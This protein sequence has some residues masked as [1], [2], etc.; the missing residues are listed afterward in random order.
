MKSP[1]SSSSAPGPR[2][3]D[4]HQQHKI[5]AVS[6]AR[7]RH[8]CIPFVTWLRQF[9]MNPTSAEEFDD[10]LVEFKNC[11]K[12]MTKSKFETLVVAVEFIFPRFRGRL[13]WAHAVITGWSFSQEIKHTVPM[14]R[15]PATLIGVIISSAGFP[16]AGAAVIIQQARGL[17]PSELL[18]LLPEHLLFSHTTAETMNKANS[19]TVRLGAKRGTK[20]KREQFVIYREAEVPIAYHLLLLL[21]QT[22]AISERLFPFS[23]WTYRRL[24]L[25]AQ[26]RLGIEVGYTPHSPRAGFATQA[27]ESGLAFADI[28]SIGRWKSEDSFRIYVD[29]IGAKQ[30]DMNLSIK[31]VQPMIEQAMQHVLDYFTASALQSKV[32]HAGEGISPRPGRSLDSSRSVSRASSSSSQVAEGGI[33]IRLPAK[34]APHRQVIATHAPRSSSRGTSRGRSPT[35]QARKPRSISRAAK[36]TQQ[37]Q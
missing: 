14:T 1:G 27:V 13:C 15:G 10:L 20:V 18:A 21:S 2:K 34:K 24:I 29:I 8:Y 36:A 22:T 30:I 12:D 32:R 6:L 11:S 26:S 3:L 5:N 4:A 16:R 25:D 35:V 31:G 37:P 33:A 23:H 28:R 7:Y 19:V 17:R 9:A